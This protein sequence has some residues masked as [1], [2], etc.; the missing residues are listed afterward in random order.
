MLDLGLSELLNRIVTG[1]KP[2][3][4][5]AGKS[6]YDTA[7][8][9]GGSYN[10]GA[11][12][13]SIKADQPLSFAQQSQ[14]ANSLSGY[15]GS[16]V[17]QSSGGN[18]GGSKTSGST[19]GGMTDAQKRLQG[20]IKDSFASTIN[21][22]KNQISG[23]PGQQQDSMAQ[24][25]QLA[26]SQQQS[27]TDALNAA[28]GKFG[29]YRDEVAGNQKNTLQD[30]ADN[31]RN[32]FSAGNNYL[33]ARGAGSS[34]ATGMYSAALTQQAN[35][36]RADIQNQTNSQYN[37]LNVAEQDTKNQHQQSIDQVNTWKAT[38]QAT[39]VSQYQDLKR[40][41]E[42]AYAGAKDSQKS[43]IANLS[44]QLLNQAQASLSNI[45]SVATQFHDQLASN[46]Q[47]QTGLTGEMTGG[48]NDLASGAASNVQ[49]QTYS[50]DGMQMDS[51]PADAQSTMDG[52]VGSINGKK[53]GS[54]DGI[55]WYSV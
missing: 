9:T 10:P 55:N 23:L 36:Q 15:T 29:G 2:T 5:T 22:Y 28:L 4:S 17:K 43:A 21:N 48:I 25:D 46:L 38:Q 32:L 6:L 45:N 44:T 47:N 27:I 14:K 41:L 51:A 7:Y 18:S 3:T 20:Q 13:Y 19:G 26:G 50:L 52:Y 24:I 16:S 11:L 40:Q 53:V 33:G 30:L 39:I 8:G 42:G 35:K 34:S 12:D 1:T 37:D 49:Q 54:Q 31:T